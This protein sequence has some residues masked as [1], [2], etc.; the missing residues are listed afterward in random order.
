MTIYAP[1]R[2]ECAGSNYQVD[3]SEHLHACE[4]NYHRCLALLPGLEA[5]RASWRYHTE[6]PSDLRIDISLLERAPYTSLICIK[7]HREGLLLPSFTVRLSHDAGVAEITEFARHRHWQ[8]RYEYPNSFMYQADEKRALNRFLSD[9][10]VFC[11]KHGLAF[12]GICDSVLVSKK[13]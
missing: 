3:L 2:L 11:R 12:D 7:Q 9:W 6:G 13:S 4:L 1:T 10:L 8:G 5:S